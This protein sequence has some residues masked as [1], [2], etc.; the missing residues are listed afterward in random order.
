M[1]ASQITQWLLGA[2]LV[3][4]ITLTGFLYSGNA[5]RLDRMEQKIDAIQAQYG[6]IAEV[7]ATVIA[8]GKQLDQIENWVRALILEGR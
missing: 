3:G 7:K 2:L 4:L 5:Q 1:K 6:Q 8:Q